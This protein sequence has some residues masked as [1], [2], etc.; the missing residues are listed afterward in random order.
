MIGYKLTVVGDGVVADVH[1]EIREYFDRLLEAF[2]RTREE[3]APL[4]TLALG[5]ATAGEMHHFSHIGVVP[6]P[7][8]NARHKVFVIDSSESPRGEKPTVVIAKVVQ[9]DT[10]L[11]E[12][13]DSTHRADDVVG[14]EREARSSERGES[15]AEPVP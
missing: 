4:L 1:I 8:G 14:Q 5:I 15:P 3:F 9:T 6:T 7:E 13:V 10:R 12:S 2:E 11:T